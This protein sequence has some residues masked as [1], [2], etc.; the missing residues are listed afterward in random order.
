MTA[1]KRLAY[2][3][4][5]ILF[6][7]AFNVQAQTPSIEVTTDDNAAQFS[8]QGQAQAVHV[9][10]YAP[11]GEL[12]FEGDSADGQPIRW[13]MV[14]RKGDRVA[15]GVYLATITVTDSTGRRRKRIEQ[16][17]VGSS[18][19][20]TQEA[21]SPQPSSSPSGSGTAGKIAKW[22]TSTALGNSVMT[23]SANKI[24]V[25]ITPTATLHVNSAQPTPLGSNGTNAPTLLQTA[26]GNGGNTTGT[27]GQ[28]GGNGAGIALYA[29]RGGDAPAGSK[30]GNGGN[31]V[32]QPGSAGGGAG[33]AGSV[34]NMFIAPSG[35][36]N[37]GVGGSSA[38]SRLTVNGNIQI[39]GA[40][41]G[42]KFADGS[43]QTKATAGTING[44]GTTNRLVK[45][46][47]PNSFGNSS[48][49]EVAGGNVGIG[50]STPAAKLDVAGTVNAQSI[51]VD[52]TAGIAVDA[53]T[54]SGG[55]GVY[56]ECKQ[57]GNNCYAL[58]GYAPTGDYA[59][60]MY[61]GKGVYA[62]SDDA[63][64]PGLDAA[65]Y[66]SNAYAVRGESAVYRGGY[67]KS[68]SNVIYSLFVDTKDGPTQGTAALSVRGTIRG[69]GDLVISGSKAGYVVDIM[70]NVGSTPLEPGDVVVIVGSGSPAL[71]QIPVVTVKKAARA[72][73]TAVAGVVDQAM[74]VPSAK[75]KEAYESQEKA[76]REAMSARAQ[77]R[78]AAR[79]DTGQ[80]MA[81]DA[82]ARLVEVAM[83]AV[84][85]S[86]E[87]G[88]L[89]ALP[90]ATSVAPGGYA[91]VVTLGAFKVI[92]AD[93]S[94]GAIHAGDLLTTSTHSGYARKVTDKVAA[95]GAIIGKALGDLTGGTGTIPVMVMQ[96]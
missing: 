53:E 39:M 54:S 37:L 86:D 57:T 6:A 21:L 68:D 85:I 42:I 74:Y 65:A 69:E 33:T 73:D 18:Q 16:L 3:L 32:L 81:R 60:Y 79:G 72:Y 20:E 58:E 75:M 30:N 77:A 5:L 92:K 15:D 31:I 29:G 61:G 25:N 44:T 90:Q 28:T 76:I 19:A 82:K 62:E 23:E 14:T 40:A 71:G 48:I 52:T 13:G 63:D 41:N 9:E 95:I 50:T 64:R 93:A 2:V 87:Q 80:P 45:F 1:V 70:E 27:T 43:I 24:G 67:F 17:T 55:E 78:E 84:T 66:G 83:P 22:A 34:G 12:V 47:G 46:T 96:K 51:L 49:T 7:L 4:A 59:G 35:L 91:S 89:H 11:S 56:A 38:P 10:V 88:T 8:A 36:G 94:F 26:G